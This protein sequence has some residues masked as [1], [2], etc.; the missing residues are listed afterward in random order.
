MKPY[1]TI[2]NHLE[3]AKEQISVLP[4]SPTPTPAINVHNFYF[5]LYLIMMMLVILK[6]TMVWGS[7]Q[8]TLLN[9]TTVHNPDPTGTTFA[10]YVHNNICHLQ[11]CQ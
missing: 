6:K 3:M 4:P 11:I 9:I 10:L 1:C 5:Y 7:L 2:S 8:I